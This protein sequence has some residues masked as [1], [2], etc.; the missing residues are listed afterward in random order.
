MIA[1]YVVR[2]VDFRMVLKVMDL[3][4][5]LVVVILTNVE[6]ESTHVIRTL[7]A[8]TNMEILIAN[9]NAD[10]VAMDSIVGI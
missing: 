9:V 10:S 6:L 1:Y 7:H 8:S 4:T 3:Q 2:L 5:E